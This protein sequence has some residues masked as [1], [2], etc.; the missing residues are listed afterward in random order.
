M[1]T[2]RTW[3][4]S[5]IFSQPGFNSDTSLNRPAYGNANGQDALYRTPKQQ[6]IL[7]QTAALYNQNENEKRKLDIEE[8]DKTAQRHLQ[9]LGIN[10][11]ASVAREG[12]AG[13][14]A[15]N[16]ANVAALMR[17]QDITGQT[18]Q[19]HNVTA[20]RG[21]DLESDRA[22][23]TTNAILRGQDLSAA[24]ARDQIATQYLT[25][26]DTIAAEDRRTNLLNDTTRRGQD[27]SATQAA[28]SDAT[29]RRGQ[30]L[31]SQH[32]NDLVK[33]E[34]MQNFVTF[35][36]DHPE[37]SSEKAIAALAQNDFTSLATILSSAHQEKIQTQ[38]PALV[39]A[40]NKAKIDKT[41][42]DSVNLFITG[43]TGGDADLTKALRE[44]IRWNQNRTETSLSS[45]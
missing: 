11:T 5:Y 40:Y 39:E 7:A 2:P 9:E 22:A 31:Q 6:L 41:N 14:N 30:D 34:R 12:I 45:S 17:G 8:L 23:A 10:T 1:P 13:E 37:I 21:Q 3:D 33:G 43:A 24:T 29:Q 36:R 18:A 4:N 38:L 32:Y 25:H 42:P 28:T 15:R 44:R 26:Q 19:M 20:L 27:L 35:V 16:A